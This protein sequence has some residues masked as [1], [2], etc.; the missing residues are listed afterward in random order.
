LA[1]Y[2][3]ATLNWPE[4]GLLSEQKCILSMGILTKSILY[5]T[6]THEVYI[7]TKRDLYIKSYTLKTYTHK[8]AFCTRDV[9]FLIRCRISLKNPKI[10]KQRCFIWEWGRG[11]GDFFFG[12]AIYWANILYRDL[13]VYNSRHLKQEAFCPDSCPKTYIII[14]S[15]WQHDQTS[16]PWLLDVH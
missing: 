13:I 4:K 6:F 16:C 7:V 15:W 12:L 5:N 3:K 2:W 10:I 1:S 9:L 14:V 11:E 8:I